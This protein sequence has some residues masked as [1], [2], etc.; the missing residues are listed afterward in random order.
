MTPRHSTRIDLMLLEEMHC[1]PAFLA[2]IAD[3]AGIAGADFV[4]AQH[5]VY[6]GNGETDVLALID[7]PNGRVALIRSRGAPVM[8][9]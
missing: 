3:R 6:R 4:S 8:P 2:W 1:S 5:S 9:R 7:T